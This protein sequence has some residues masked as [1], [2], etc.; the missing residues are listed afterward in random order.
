MW[1]VPSRSLSLN[2]SRAVGYSH[3]SITGRAPFPAPTQ[4][5]LAGSVADAE[6]SGAAAARPGVASQARGENLTKFRI[7]AYDLDAKY[8]KLLSRVSDDA[9]N[10]IF[11]DSSK[12][13]HY[14]TALCDARG[15]RQE[16]RRSAS[17]LA[18][19]FG[20]L[21]RVK[22]PSRVEDMNASV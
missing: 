3:S 15:S 18:R 16:S 8:H 11:I 2:C 4:S 9:E 7:E 17:R 13:K 19:P 12:V 10:P 21:K 14:V 5:S 1:R 20:R 22:R 6:V